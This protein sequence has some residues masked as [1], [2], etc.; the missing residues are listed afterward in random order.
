MCKKCLWPNFECH[1]EISREILAKMTIKEIFDI[2][3]SY[4]RIT[5]L[6]TEVCTDMNSAPCMS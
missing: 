1:Q 3:I 6:L 2:D 4:F 5:V